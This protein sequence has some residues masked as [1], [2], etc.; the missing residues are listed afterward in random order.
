MSDKIIDAFKPFRDT[1]DKEQK[2]LGLGHRPMSQDVAFDSFAGMNL[3][4]LAVVCIMLINNKKEGKSPNIKDLRKYDIS[5]F[6]DYKMFDVYIKHMMRY[7]EAKINITKKL[8]SPRKGVM[9]SGKQFAVSHKPAVKVA[10]KSTRD[11]LSKKQSHDLKKYADYVAT[12]IRYML[13]LQKKNLRI[14]VTED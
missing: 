14:V 4:I 5:S 1:M 10:K 8:E 6:E 13:Y 11:L 12:F 2:A 9:R 3:G 7:K